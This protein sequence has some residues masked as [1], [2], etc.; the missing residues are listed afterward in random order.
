MHLRQ[1]PRIAVER[2]FAHPI[3]LAEDTLTGNSVVVG[4]ALY[5][6]KNRLLV[7]VYEETGQHIRIVTVHPIRASQ[8]RMRL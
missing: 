4:E 1:I 3:V 5:G 8:Y 7:V 6:G 2:V